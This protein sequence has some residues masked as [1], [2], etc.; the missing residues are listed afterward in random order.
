MHITAPFSSQH[1]SQLKFWAV[2]DGAPI[3]FVTSAE[4]PQGGGLVDRLVSTA[5][6][7]IS[8]SRHFS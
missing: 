8:T 5:V 4:L 7:P 6:A 2:S 3:S 1:G